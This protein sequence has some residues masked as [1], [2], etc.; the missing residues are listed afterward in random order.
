MN[1]SLTSIKDQTTIIR[2]RKGMTKA[3]VSGKES[4]PVQKETDF[5]IRLEKDCT[6][7]LEI[8]LTD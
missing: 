7:Q 3:T 2:Y 5:M 4:L 6:I 8:L 1:V